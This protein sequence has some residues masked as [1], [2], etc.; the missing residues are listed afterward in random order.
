MVRRSTVAV[1]L[2][3]LALAAGMLWVGTRWY[4]AADVLLRDRLQ[5]VATVVA[6]RTEQRHSSVDDR[7]IQGQGRRPFVDE[8]LPAYE[9]DIPTLRFTTGDGRQVEVDGPVLKPGS[10]PLGSALSVHY[11]PQQPQGAR[12]SADLVQPLEAYA[13]WAFGGALLLPA[14][15]LLVQAARRRV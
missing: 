2:V 7:E 10:L 11:L 1:G 8:R 3:F 5:A 9:V 14:L 4:L 12:A 15:V 13:L 6:L